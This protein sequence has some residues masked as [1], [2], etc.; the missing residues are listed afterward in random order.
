ME[1]VLDALLDA[2]IDTLK[3][4]PFLLG[5]YIIMEYLE[6][7]TAE[8]QISLMEKAGWFAPVVGAAAGAVPQCGFSASAAS[9]YS[10]GVV[11]LGTMLAVF[12]STSDEM[13]PILLS[14]HAPVAGILR[15]LAA[16]AVIGMAT[17][18]LVDAVLRGLKGR[19]GNG[20]DI[21]DLCEREHC[22]CEEDEEEG[23]IRPALTH[24]AHILLFVFLISFVITLIVEGL[25][26]E[27]IGSFLTA[28]PGLG[29]LLSGLIGLIPNCAASVI[30]TSL[31]LQGA[32]S[33]GSMI[34][35]LLVGSGVGLL[36]L[37]R[38]DHNWKDDLITLAI[39]FV[40]GV[41][42]GMVAGWTGLF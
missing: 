27:A 21:H 16:K 17:G 10:G 12:L 29:I 2:V 4:V 8:R 34:A 42:L 11:S 25:G 40:S 18:L 14:E 26:E 23:I 3:L 35:G 31:Y 15:I 1:M 6:R 37:L 30:L 7:R 32:M 39:L 5:T 41:L 38:M 24:T 20:K 36:V 13:L 28:R 22:G 33:A 19:S 9:L